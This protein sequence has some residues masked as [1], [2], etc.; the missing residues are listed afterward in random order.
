MRARPKSRVKVSLL[1]RDLEDPVIEKTTYSKA[2]D[3][4]KSFSIL[5]DVYSIVERGES[6]DQGVTIE[7]IGENDND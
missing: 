7:N 3:F 1:R 4:V 5:G 6:F 2:F